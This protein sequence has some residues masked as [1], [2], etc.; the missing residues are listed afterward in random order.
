[1][2]GPRSQCYRASYNEK[3]AFASVGLMEE[4]GVIPAAS[5]PDHHP[6]VALGVGGF[7]V[8]ASNSPCR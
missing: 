1:M 4:Y 5:Y 2:D 6:K 8:D 7:T 3:H